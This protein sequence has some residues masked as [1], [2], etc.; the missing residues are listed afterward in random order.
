MTPPDS[1]HYSD[2]AVLEA[3]RENAEPWTEI[4][5]AQ[6]IETRRLVTDHAVVDAAL[7]AA[8][9]SALDLG[10][11][12][13][14]LTR[15]LIGCDIDTR[16]VDAVPALIEAARRAD[17]GAPADRYACLSYEA[18]ARGALNARYDLVLCNFSLLG[19]EV[20]AG[21]MAAVPSLLAPRGS[22]IIQTVHPLLADAD[23][24]YQNGW[25]DGNWAGCEAAFGDPAPWYFRTIGSWVG[26]IRSSGMELRELVEPLHPVTLQPASLILVAAVPEP[27]L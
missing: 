10:C 13:G 12:E 6:A 19:F 20:V 7:R 18:I 3:W 5:R 11:G 4:V 14:W 2:A 1:K 21:L 16:G 15:A 22:L 26:L 17:P 27:P 8:P 23:A 25:R 9:R 24:P